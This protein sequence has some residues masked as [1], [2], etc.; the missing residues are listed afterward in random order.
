MWAEWGARNAVIP[1]TGMTTTQSVAVGEDTLTFECS[2]SQP[3]SGEGYGT[4]AATR[5]VAASP[6][7][8][9]RDALDDLYNRGGTGTANQM[10]NS[11]YTGTTRG[12]FRA[13][14]SCE[15]RLTGPSFPGTGRQVPLDG[16]VVADAETSNLGEYTMIEASSTATWHVLERFKNPGCTVTTM[17][18]VT[19]IPG[20]QSLKLSP[21]AS[22]QLCSI[23]PVPVILAE[24]ISEATISARSA[25][26]AGVAV[27]AVVNVDYGDAPASYGATGAIY[28]PGWTGPTLPQGTS[29]A[30]TPQLSKL[31]SPGIMLGSLIDAEQPYPPNSN[32]TADDVTGTNG[33]IDDEDAI[34][35]TPEY[36]VLRGGPASQVVACTGTGH[37]RGWIDW[38]RNGRFEDAEVSDPAACTNGSAT[39]TWRVPQ[40]TVSGATYLRLRAAATNEELQRP[41]GLTPTGEVEDHQVSVHVGELGITKRSD[42]LAGQKYVGHEVTYSVALTNTGATAF[43]SAVPAHLVDDLTRLLDDAEL[44]TDSIQS[45]VNGAARGTARFDSATQRI[46]WSGALNSGETATVSYRVKLKLGGDRIL[47]NVAWGLTNPESQTSS[48]SCESR[49]ETGKDTESGLPCDVEQYSLLSLLKRFETRYNPTPDA[50]EWRLQAHGD[51][52][53]EADDTLREVVGAE[54]ANATN[55]FV[56]P[57][58]STFSFTESATASVQDGY[59]FTNPTQTGRG[60]EV[61]ELINRDLPATLTWSKTD[62]VTE[63]LLAGSAWRLT[64]PTAPDGLDIADCVAPDRSGCAGPDVDP[65]AGAFRLEGLS[66]GLHALTETLAPMGYAPLAAPVSAEV[67]PGGTELVTDLG[68]I[69]N[70]RL[71]GSI[72]WSKVAEDSGALLAGSVWTLTPAGG[73]ALPDIADCTGGACDGLLDK[74][75]APGRFLVR[76]LSWGTWTLAEKHAPVGYYITTRIEHVELG[77]LHREHVFAAAFE[78]VRMPVPVLPMTGGTPSDL[79]LISG[80]GLLCVA[81]ALIGV[82]N[83]RKNSPITAEDR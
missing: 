51:F 32:G 39:L 22:P 2:I 42:A 67:S 35:G 23:A 72:T 19:T 55:T 36:R 34:S 50:S 11:L 7:A 70:Q 15:A 79:F 58:T 59:E 82:R 12:Y 10:T 80:G 31:R 37:V 9:G 40:D 17:A 43:T 49:S 30:F 16:L 14:I 24:G 61:V 65:T 53:G 52:G 81:A 26:R 57:A 60:G 18:E 64:G 38:D 1:A 13:K 68:R 27:G 25:G 73:V 66:W 47:R 77:A 63:E 54:E 74:D 5:I 21:S 20:G 29:D 44:V 45:T 75:P 28:Q 48:V 78:N 71:G 33:R 46:T 62:A 3:D 76:D 41:T 4:T 69:K 83:R 56:V 8:Y 6:G